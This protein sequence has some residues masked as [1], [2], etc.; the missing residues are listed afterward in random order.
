MAT[1][2]VGST[3]I[4]KLSKARRYRDSTGDM[5]YGCPIANK[6]I[7]GNK[8]VATAVR[9]ESTK[10]D[11]F[12]RIPNTGNVARIAASTVAPKKVGSTNSNKKRANK[13]V[14]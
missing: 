3:S 14:M 7:V 2:S 11:G 4:M 5:P 9:L 10:T 6:I 1:A 12:C 13:N 8:I